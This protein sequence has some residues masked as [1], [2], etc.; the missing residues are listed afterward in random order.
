MK[1]REEKVINEEFLTVTGQ[2][3]CR[4]PFNGAMEEVAGNV[5]SG[6]R[7]RMQKRQRINKMRFLTNVGWAFA[8]KVAS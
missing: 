1:G 2:V 3:G 7:A 6:R 4:Q 5:K 8:I